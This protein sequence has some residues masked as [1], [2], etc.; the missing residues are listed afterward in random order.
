MPAFVR[1]QR[2]PLAWIAGQIGE[3]GV[4]GAAMLALILGFLAT[5]KQGVLAFIWTKWMT[6]ARVAGQIGETGVFC[7]TIFAIVAHGVFAF[8][9]RVAVAPDYPKPSRVIAIVLSAKRCRS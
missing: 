9:V 7:S 3:T 6:H 5:L 4:A 2:M 8:V 1:S